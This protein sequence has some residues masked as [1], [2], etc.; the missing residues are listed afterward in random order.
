[1]QDEETRMQLSAFNY[2][3]IDKLIEGADVVYKGYLDA[4]KTQ[5]N[6]GQLIA[7]YKMRNDTDKLIEIEANSDPFVLI[8][9]L[10][11]HQKSE[12]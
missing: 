9:I 10:E 4:F 12:Q 2:S 3:I 11:Q 1:M 7:I 8:P 5:G 6:L